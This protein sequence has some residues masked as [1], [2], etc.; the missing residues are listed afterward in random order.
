MI[1][2]VMITMNEQDAVGKVITD[3][4]KVVPSAEIVIVDSSKDKT[5]EI[6][7][8]LGAKVI[9]QIPPKGYGP[10]MDLALRSATG[11]VIVT[12]DCDD[13]YPVDKIPV[14]ADKILKDGFDIID[15]SRL[16][17]KPKFM[18]WINYLANW[19]FAKIASVLF[20]KNFT[21]LHSGMRAYRKT[22]IDKLKFDNR[23]VSLPVELLLKP[24]KY[25]YKYDYIFIEYK[26]RIGVSKLEPLRAAWWTVKRILGVRF[27]K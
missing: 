16:K 24:I 10:A 20:L 25:G 26:E 22:M 12:L 15:A 21:D 27:C 8:E 9:K 19:G 2:I 13:T 18:P 14:L 3:I 23:G 5:A 6:A 11:D 17:S 4:K 1:S 7:E